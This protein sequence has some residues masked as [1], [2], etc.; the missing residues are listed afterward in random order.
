MTSMMITSQ[1]L[2]IL[3]LQQPYLE[4]FRTYEQQWQQFHGRE[5]KRGQ[6]SYRTTNMMAVN[7]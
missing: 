5:C 7:R 4:I 1:P 6:Y 2:I 3:P